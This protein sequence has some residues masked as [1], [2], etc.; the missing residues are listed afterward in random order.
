LSADSGSS[1]RA[2]I[3]GLLG[4]G[5]YPLSLVGALLG[6]RAFFRLSAP[7][8][9]GRTLAIV[10]M[11]MPALVLPVTW[12]EL[13]AARAPMRRSQ[14][15]KWQPECK[16]QLAKF[17]AA[18][19]DINHRTGA[20]TMDR[21]DLGATKLP[22]DQRY[23]Y[24]FGETAWMVHDDKLATSQLAQMKKLGVAVGLHGGTFTIACV[25]LMNDW[26]DVWTVSSD[27]REFEGGKRVLPAGT[28]F[29]EYSDFAK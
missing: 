18:E 16:Q 29:N 2:I 21:D 11:L 9:P 27:D 7:G 20:F 13:R 25:A 1:K 8:T 28:P 14:V 26:V 17:W 19:Q 4:I 22:A 5:C 24:L 3:V 6:L 23:S 10:A 15:A 12:L